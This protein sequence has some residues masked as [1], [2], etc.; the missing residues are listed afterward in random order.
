MLE[1]AYIQKIK[2]NKTNKITHLVS[3]VSFNIFVRHE[4]QTDK[5]KEIMS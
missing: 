4:T 2:Y 3:F 1:K 5:R